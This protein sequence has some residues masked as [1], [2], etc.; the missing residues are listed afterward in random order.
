MITKS[1][2]TYKDSDGNTWIKIGMV[3][4]EGPIAYVTNMLWGEEYVVGDAIQTFKYGIVVVDKYLFNSIPK[5]IKQYDLMLRPD[6]Q[7]NVWTIPFAVRWTM[8]GCEFSIY[9]GM[10]CFWFR[11]ITWDDER[12]IGDTPIV[13]LDEDFSSVDQYKILAEEFPDDSDMYEAYFPYL[14]K[15]HYIMGYGL[16]GCLYDSC[17]VY[18]SKE[19]A[20]ESAKFL[21]EIDDERAD[22]LDR[23][24]ICAGYIDDGEDHSNDIS[25]IEI[26]ECICWTPWDHSESSRQDVIEALK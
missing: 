18:A 16:R 21:Y 26:S 1:E 23:F 7:P 19:A 25:I 17:D 10:G 3:K 13:F 2:A 22:E 8:Q 5:E 4:Y 14:N 12:S 24:N 6:P 9:E 20:V 15:P 11:N